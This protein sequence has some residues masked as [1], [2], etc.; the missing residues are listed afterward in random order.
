MSNDFPAGGMVGPDLTGLGSLE[1]TSQVG[2]P[3]EA[4]ELSEWLHDPQSIKPG[5]AMPAAPSLGLD[6]E[7]IDQLVEYLM[8]LE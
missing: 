1:E 5:T 6:D 3:V 2:I 4:E 7:Q 8:N